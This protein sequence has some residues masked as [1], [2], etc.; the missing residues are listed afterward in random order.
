MR[1]LLVEDNADDEFLARVALKRA[2]LEQVA[3]ARDGSLAL[4]ML[5]GDGEGGPLPDLII[6]DLRLPK[7]DGLQVLQKIRE[8]ARTMTLPVLVL[9]SSEDPGDKESC[10][11]LGIIDFVTKPLTP[12]LLVQLLG[13]IGKEHSP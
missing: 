10:R 8:D 12:A 7:I 11:R 6:L 4:E 13:S 9:T 3:V 1:I 2:G 5:Y